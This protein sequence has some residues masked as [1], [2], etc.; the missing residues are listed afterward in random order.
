[1]FAEAIQFD[2]GEIVAILLVVLAVLASWLLLLIG[3]SVVVWRF[4]RGSGS[5]K[6]RVR[7]VA[8]ADVLL[9]LMSVPGFDSTT[10]ILAL[11]L[12]LHVVVYAV[13]R[14]TGPPEADQL[15]S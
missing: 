6:G 5:T 1:V 7:T 15:G 4:T 11:P 3:G 10:S 9:C 12:L 14:V 13:A 2:T 8:V